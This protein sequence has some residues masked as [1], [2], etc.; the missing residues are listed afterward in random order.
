VD[1]VIMSCGGSRESLRP[2][3]RE[4]MPAFRLTAQAPEQLL[5]VRV[6]WRSTPRWRGSSALFFGEESR[7]VPL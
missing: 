1:Y 4:I 5:D 7:A 3:A 2:F 6:V